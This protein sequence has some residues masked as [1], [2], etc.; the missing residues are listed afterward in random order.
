MTFVLLWL[1]ISV[2]EQFLFS[3]TYIWFIL[4]HATVLN[5]FYNMTFVLLWLFISVAEQFWKADHDETFSKAD[6]G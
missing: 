3:N 2:A 4:Q 1:F 6:C 5:N